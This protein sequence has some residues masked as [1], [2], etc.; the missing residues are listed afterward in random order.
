MTVNIGDIGF[1]LPEQ[2]AIDLSDADSWDDTTTTDYT[3]ATERKGKDFYIYACD[4]SGALTLLLSANSTHP[5]GYGDTNSRKIGGFHCL[6]A[7]VG[8][9]SGHTLSELLHGRGYPPGIGLGSQTPARV[10]SGG[11]GLQ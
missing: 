3:A 10:R 8:T 2:Q 5:N 11:D 1:Y 9:I 4:D 6:C 7:D